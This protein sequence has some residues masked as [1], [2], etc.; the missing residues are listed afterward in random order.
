MSVNNNLSINNH[1][2]NNKIICKDNLNKYSRHRNH[3][4]NKLIISNIIN[5]H[6]LHI[7]NHVNNTYTLITMSLIK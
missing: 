3:V 6:N 7:N 2:N 5:N 1:V 4:N